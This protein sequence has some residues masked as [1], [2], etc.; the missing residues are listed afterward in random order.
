MTRLFIDNQEAVLP[1]S[2]N[3]DLIISNPLITA[4]GAVTYDIDLNLRN[5]V[6]ARLYRHINRINVTTGITGRRALLQ[7]DG[8]TIID[9]EEILLKIDGHTAKIQVVGGN[10]EFNH[11]TADL[12]IRDLDLGQVTPA[13]G[14]TITA[15]DALPTLSGCYPQFDH[16]FTPVLLRD[17]EF[18]DDVQ[19]GSSDSWFA[20]SFRNIFTVGSTPPGYSV[21]ATFA[22]Q[23]Y[24]LAIARRLFTAMGYT[25]IDLSTLEQDQA[26]CRL[27]IVNES[28][29][30]QYNEML[31]NWTV[32]KFVDE[33]EKFFNVVIKVDN[34]AKTIK[35]VH[36]RTF[37]DTAQKQYIKDEDIFDEFEE[38]FGCEDDAAERN[39]DNVSYNLPQ[40]DWYRYAA[41]DEELLDKAEIHQGSAVSYQSWVRPAVAGCQSDEQEAE[42]DY[43]TLT[44]FRTT[45]AAD[46][47]VER[48]PEAPNRR[49]QYPDEHEFYYYSRCVDFLHPVVNK[50]SSSQTTLNIVPAETF[51]LNIFYN[52][53]GEFG[54]IAIAAVPYCRDQPVSK[55][56]EDK[57]EKEAERADGTTPDNGM[58]EYILQGLPR[59][60]VSQQVFV[61]FYAGVIPMRQLRTGSQ[62]EG[63]SYPTSLVFPVVNHVANHGLFGEVTYYGCAVYDPRYDLSPAY[64]HEHYYSDNLRYDP[65][66]Q[67]T[68]T[69]RTKGVTLDPCRIYI[70]RNRAFYCRQLKYNIQ[71][72]GLHT[73]VEGIFYPLEDESE[74]SGTSG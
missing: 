21:R 35:A 9:G 12:N 63:L 46:Q 3:V 23:P 33:F 38:K 27:Y 61:A 66:I 58:H 34:F 60:E 64:R 31:P 18:P 57:E 53:G 28:Q 25:S 8:R 67:Y 5:H 7:C 20:K 42:D 56:G 45:D 13:V 55:T 68:V 65:T 39:Y 72:Q 16:V 51:P 15:A 44:I 47:I 54:D 73:I 43:N 14:D 22:A 6:N 69:F 11:D 74:G 49:W 52:G 37:Y 17:D 26:N 59:R 70:I 62:V 24:I 36:Q 50:Q 32:E 19:Q 40:S 41:L 30:L 1:D 2:I 10:S 29:S 4:E 48:V 71:P